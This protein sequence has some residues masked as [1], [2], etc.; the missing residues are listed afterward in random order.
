MASMSVTLTDPNGNVSLDH[1]NRANMVKPCGKGQK[2][3]RT[4]CLFCWP[5][6]RVF[7]GCYITTNKISGHRNPVGL[8]LCRNV[9]STNIITTEECLPTLGLQMPPITPP[10]SNQHE[11]GFCETAPRKLPLATWGPHHQQQHISLRSCPSTTKIPPTIHILAR[12]A[13]G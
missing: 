8:K 1:K 12:L 10:D 11:F 13:P 4:L 9:F 7:V 5:I 3:P 2:A 6:G